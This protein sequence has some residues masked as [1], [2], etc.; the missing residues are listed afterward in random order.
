VTGSRIAFRVDASLEIG[1]GHVIRCLTLAQALRKN[2]AECRFI[3]RDLPGHLADRIKKA[4][5][6]VALLPAAPGPLPLPPPVY[7]SWAGVNW[8]Q[9]AI[10]TQEAVSGIELDW[11]I[12]DHYAFDARW[13]QA[14]CRGN[15]KLLVID[16]LADRPHDCDLL[17]DQNLGRRADDYD[18]L[19]SDHCTRLIGPEYALLRPEF[20]ELRAE[21][22]VSR[23][24]RR[25][26][27]LMISM[28]GID[29]ADA[30]STVLEALREAPLP[31]DLQ[32]SVIMG[33]SAPALEDVRKLA[34]DMHWPTEVDVDVNDMAERM[35]TADLAIGAGGSTTWERC[36]L[37]LPAIV[38]QTAENQAAAAV[39]MA[40]DGAALAPKPL[41]APDFAQSLGEVLA[42]AADSLNLGSLSEAAAR[43]CDGDGAARVLSKLRPMALTFRDARRADSRRVW[44][45]RNA[46]NPTFSLLNEET[47][48]G[49]HDAWFC[50]ALDDAERNIRIALAG[51]LPCGYLRIDV[52]DQQCGRVSVCLA[53][54]AKGRGLGRKLLAEADRLAADLGLFRLNA[55][56]NIRNEASRRVFKAAGYVTEKK[57][58]SFLS[59]YR[60]LREMA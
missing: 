42:E 15:A 36:C 3:T 19:V 13:E 44:E 30:T 54:D 22:L 18:G 48:Y 43:I 59:C 20:A 41:F 27:N 55:E 21:A 6:D 56:I 2:G 9:D 8:E 32:I 34:A 60:T 7:A 40:K 37:G 14:V 25:L 12:V 26:K 23:G 10:E 1:T 50:A 46:V 28:G 52:I 16:D 49:D 17:L 24:G 45:W 39:S 57:S 4:G 29:A 11:L 31:E 38:I 58:G 51:D 35:A 53:S 33:S 5:F 47:A